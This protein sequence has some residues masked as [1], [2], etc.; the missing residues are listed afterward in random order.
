[1][2]ILCAGYRSF[3]TSQKRRKAKPRGGQALDKKK[4][5]D[6][7]KIIQGFGEDEEAR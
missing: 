7:L 4:R 5:K 2:I 6:A 1:M 3:G